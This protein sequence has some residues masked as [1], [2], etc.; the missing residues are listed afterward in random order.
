MTARRCAIMCSEGRFRAFL[1][2]ELSEPGVKDGVPDD[3][4]WIGVNTPGEASFAVRYLLGITT[5]KQ[6]DTEGAAAQRWDAMLD[7]FEAWKWGLI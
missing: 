1:Q 7:K 3:A 2:S 5:R 4:P 6:L